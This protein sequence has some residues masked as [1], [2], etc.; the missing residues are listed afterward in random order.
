MSSA[1]TAAVGTS[2][3]SINAQMFVAELG[4]HFVSVSSVPQCRRSDATT[5]SIRVHP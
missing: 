3:P 5:A 1:A 2:A 4:H